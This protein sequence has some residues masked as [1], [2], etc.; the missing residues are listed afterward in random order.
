MET[1]DK[2]ILENKN[3][4]ITSQFETIQSQ[5]RAIEQDEAMLGQKK[6]EMNVELFRLQGE[7][8]LIKDLLE[9][10]APSKEPAV[11]TPNE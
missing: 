11:E 3:K 2:T 10:P 5:I 6:K 9:K 1:L 8:R 4:E 7:H